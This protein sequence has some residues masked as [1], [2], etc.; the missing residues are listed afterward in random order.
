M[1]D[2]HGNIIINQ[3]N[4]ESQTREHNLQN[5]LLT[6]TDR[7][8]E[9]NVVGE[10]YLEYDDN[11]NLI[12][13][14]NGST[15]QFDAW[16]RVATANTGNVTYRYDGLGRRVREGAKT[17]YY[18]D[19][20][21]AIEERTTS[22]NLVTE[23]Y[24]WSPAYI[25]A[26]IRR[27][28]DTDANGTTD[29]TV[30][31]TYDANFNVT[32]IITASSQVPTV[33]E[34]FQYDAYGAKT[35]L[36][37]SWATITDAYAFRHGFAGGKQDLATGRVHF[38]NRDYDPVLARWISRD[39]IGYIG[40]EWNLYEYVGSNPVNRQDP[41]GL[42]FI[43]DDT[44]TGPV[45]EIIV[46]SIFAPWIIDKITN[47]IIDLGDA[48][49]ETVD[50][51]IDDIYSDPICSKRKGERGQM[52]D[53]EGTD[54]PWKHYKPHPT[55]P[56]KVIFKDPHTGKKIVKPRPPDFPT[57]PTKPTQ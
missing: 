47:E 14:Q 20:W 50:Y 39:P 56:D 30:H 9:D 11:G 19:K 13:D 38:R 35:T 24:V 10:S 15:L 48:I 16:N 43:I 28:R 32:S 57:P 7:D 34:R 52:H 41:S 36:N 4:G 49:V 27:H 53:P 40:S 26:M 51:I 37:A 44:V 12:A 45:D 8:E 46:I 22:S 42:W 18:N 33:V 23:Q 55:D 21:Q 25:D 54:N 5:E 3:V 29:E 31:V 1:R 2:V 6:L 17:I